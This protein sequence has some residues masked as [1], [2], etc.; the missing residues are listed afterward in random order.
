MPPGCKT[1]T[2]YFDALEHSFV[3]W[4]IFRPIPIHPLTL[5]IPSQALNDHSLKLFAKLANA[6]DLRAAFGEHSKASAKSPTVPAVTIFAPT[7]AVR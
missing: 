3:P 5:T 4:P 1:Q 2:C 7:D 6:A